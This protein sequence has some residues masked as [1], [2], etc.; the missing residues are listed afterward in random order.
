MNATHWLGWLVM[1]ASLALTGCSNNNPA[2][3]SVASG[4]KLHEVRGTVLAVDASKPSVKL[5][6]EDIPGIMEAMK[7]TFDVESPGV[8]QGIQPGDRV[9]GQLKVG[10]GQFTIVHLQKH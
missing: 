1:V 10:A 7:M 8:L 5:D 3:K 6:H 4:D 2:G 9:H